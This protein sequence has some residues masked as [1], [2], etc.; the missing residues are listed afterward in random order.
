MA[1]SRK[2]QSDFLNSRSFASLDFRRGNAPEGCR[3]RNLTKM[4]SNAKEEFSSSGVLFFKSFFQVQVQ[5]Y[6][7][8]VSKIGGGSRSRPAKRRGKTHGSSA[9]PWR[10]NRPPRQEKSQGRGQ[11][12]ITG[13]PAQA[14]RT[15]PKSPLSDQKVPQVNRDADTAGQRGLVGPC[16]PPAQ[17]TSWRCCSRGFR[18]QGH[19]VHM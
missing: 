10:P 7:R 4:K 12:P 5:D 1:E 19:P 8:Q 2:C 11:I 9:H 17:I 13:P 6:L 18:S 3:R 16:A 15:R 14:G